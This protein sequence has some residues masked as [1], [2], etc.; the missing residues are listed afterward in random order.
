VLAGNNDYNGVTT[1]TTGTL[2][3][4]NSNGLGSNLSPTTIQNTG[5]L[6]LA[7]NALSTEPVFVNSP[8]GGVTGA[9]RSLSGNNALGDVTMNSPANL[10]VDLGTLTVGRLA[11]LSPATKVGAGQLNAFH[12]R[13]DRLT[14]DAGTVAITAG[15]DPLQKLSRVS[16]LLLDGNSTPTTT[17]DLNDNDFIS[18]EPG[19]AGTISAQIAFARHSGAWDRPGITSTSARTNPQHNT[20]LGVLN[21]AEYMSVNSG[22]FDGFA[23]GTADTLIKYTYYGDTDFNGKVNF[24]DYVRTDSGFNNH[25]SGW[26]NGDFDGNGQVNFD[27]YVLIDLAF[28]TQS[29]TL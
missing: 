24:D 9:I 27:D 4:T 15:G 20:T 8:G 22:T 7:N 10:A 11:G 14:I 3:V 18:T 21:G 17:L 16:Q 25:K 29:G 23:V 2:R 26:V 1:I 19:S 6:E 28:N 5:A 12:V 13:T